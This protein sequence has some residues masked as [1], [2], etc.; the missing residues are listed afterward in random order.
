MTVYKK[1]ACGEAKVNVLP[2]AANF[3]GVIAGGSTEWE[4]NSEVAEGGE[5]V[6]YLRG[7]K[8]CGVLEEGL[9]ATVFRKSNGDGTYEAVAEGA[10]VGYGHQFPRDGGD[11]VFGRAR[12]WCSIAKT[13]GQ[14]EPC[15]MLQQ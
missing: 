2:V 14:A 5:L 8:L 7:R 9:T 6:N 12:E 1:D 10:V 3:D 11:D 15:G 4:K 13:V